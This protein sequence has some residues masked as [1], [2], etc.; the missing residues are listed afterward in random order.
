MA[1]PHRNPALAQLDKQLKA[2]H[3]GITIGWIADQHHSSNSEHQPDPDGTVDALDP[4]LGPHYSWEDAHRDV[5][6]LVKSRDKRIWY[7]I[8][9]GKIISSQVNPWIW[10]TYTGTDKHTNHFHI[11]TVEQNEDSNVEWHIYTRRNNMIPTIEIG[12]TKPLLRKGMTDNDMP[13]GVHHISRMQRLLGITDDGIFGTLTDTAL[14]KYLG[15]SYKGTVD[16]DAWRKILGL[17]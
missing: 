12:G 14:K 11:C 9:D 13:G 6:A 8:W 17:W 1:T 7:I 5:N 10:R 15:S 2:E 16:T 3:P 4:M